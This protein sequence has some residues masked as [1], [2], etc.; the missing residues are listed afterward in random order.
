MKHSLYFLIIITLLF[1]GCRQK[2]QSN[3][4]SESSAQTEESNPSLE[5]YAEEAVITGKVLNRDFYPQEK[6][7]TLIIPFFRDMGNQYRSPIQKDGSF[8]FRFPETSNTFN[9]CQPINIVTNRLCTPSTK[10][11]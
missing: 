4:L 6:E 11:Q 2:A 8:S 1:A 3:F 5:E 7:L 9:I 10:P